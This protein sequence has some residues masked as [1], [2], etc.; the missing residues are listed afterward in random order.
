MTLQLGW[1]G[2]WL[3]ER[4]LH[5]FIDRTKQAMPVTV[6]FQVGTIRGRI[7]VDKID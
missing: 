5:E 3:L 2:R 4:A 6:F 7:V 1:F